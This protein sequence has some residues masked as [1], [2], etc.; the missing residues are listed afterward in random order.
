MRALCGGLEE[1]GTDRFEERLIE[2]DTVCECFCW[3]PIDAEFE[4]CFAMLSAILILM[5]T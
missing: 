2:T 3:Q 1:S 4:E 5:L